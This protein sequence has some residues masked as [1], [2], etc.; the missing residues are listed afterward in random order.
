MRT[1][2]RAT[3]ALAAAA[4]A[5]LLGACATTPPGAKPATVATTEDPWC[6]TSTGSRIPAV[7]GYCTGIGQ[8]YS[9]T[10][11]SS[12]GATSAADALRLLSPS[13]TI[14]H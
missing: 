8:S 11:I 12:T 14:S 1:A 2:H 13:L 6:L 5:L 10:D 3:T 9:S 4:G 7:K